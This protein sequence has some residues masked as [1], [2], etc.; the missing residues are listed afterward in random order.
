MVVAGREGWVVKE[1]GDLLR[2]AREARQLT[3]EQIHNQTKISVRY[4]A[5]IEEGRFDELPGEVYLK[6]FLRSY[7][8]AVGLNPE[9]ILAEYKQRKAEREAI[10]KQE[11][12][13]VGRGQ[14]GATPKVQVT[15]VQL[16]AVV[17]A[18][19]LII[20]G[21]VSS[22]LI[23]YFGSG[24]H[25]TSREAE[26]AVHETA[27]P[28]AEERE[29]APEGTEPLPSETAPGASQPAFPE[30]GSVPGASRALPSVTPTPS[31]TSATT[32]VPQL[33]GAS[34]SSV[35]VA[36]PVRVSVKVIEPCW[37]SVNADGR[38]VYEGTLGA[39]AANSWQANRE[40]TLKLGRPGGAEILFNGRS[41]GSVGKEV[42]T[43]LF[44]PQE[45]KIVSPR[46]AAG[47]APKREE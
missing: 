4:L 45:W 44:T 26:V 13:Q 42:V 3:L 34:A 47:S 39:G 38:L 20:S 36:A 37:V 7:A 28:A 27:E 5:A 6:G 9:A 35:P 8:E 41:I 21:L 1:V 23:S 12:T 46:A 14:K 25:G 10:M 33:E 22:L 16:S 15:R 2:Q 31:A 40:L 17:V 18:L 43:L 32:A 24:G 19:V 11:E 30:T 29:G